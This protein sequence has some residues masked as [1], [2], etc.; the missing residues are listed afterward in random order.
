MVDIDVAAEAEVVQIAVRVIAQSAAEDEG[1][2][3][4]GDAVWVGVGVEDL[5]EID[6]PEEVD[7]ERAVHVDVD[8]FRIARAGDIASIADDIIDR[9]VIVDLGEAIAVAVETSL[10]DAAAE[11]IGI[12]RDA[13]D[14]GGRS[15]G[16]RE[17]A[18][19]VVDEV[20]I[21]DSAVDGDAD[22]AG[23]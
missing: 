19:H 17:G 2:V 15:C 9:E 21:G 11:H 23:F 7:D 3:G 18:V 5:I 8:S 20:F 13:V 4:I 22:H 6:S 14:A 10:A 16:T 1:R 12:E